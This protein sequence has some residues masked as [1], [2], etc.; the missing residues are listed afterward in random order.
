L[1]APACLPE[2]LLSTWHCASGISAG[3]RC[4]HLLTH[5][6]QVVALTA[7]ATIVWLD[8][9]YRPMRVPE[10]VRAALAQKQEDFIRSGTK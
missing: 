1:L 7:T 9:S 5:H 8:G 2:G 3:P 4:S 6:M 10:G